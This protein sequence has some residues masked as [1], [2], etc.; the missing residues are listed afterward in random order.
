VTE[1]FETIDDVKKF[2]IKF[3]VEL[4]DPDS[5]S[6]VK[7]RELEDIVEIKYITD[8]NVDKEVEE[9]LA[10]K[11]AKKKL[12]VEKLKE[13]QEIARRESELAQLQALKE[14]YENL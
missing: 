8:I 12:E 1:D 7:D 9:I 13:R 6:W 4:K 5:D 11:A 10:V 3:Q 2:L 14:K